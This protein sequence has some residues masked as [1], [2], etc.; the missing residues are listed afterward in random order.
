MYHC[1][2]WQVSFGMSEQPNVHHRGQTEDGIA[3]VV[4]EG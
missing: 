2:E 1:A 4:P 3:D